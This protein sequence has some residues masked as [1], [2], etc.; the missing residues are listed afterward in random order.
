VFGSVDL[1]HIPFLIVNLTRSV[2]R[3]VGFGVM[4]GIL[5]LLWLWGIVAIAVYEPWPLWLRLVVALLWAVLFPLA[6]ITIPHRVQPPQFTL[7]ILAVTLF[8][9]FVAIRV[10]W[11]FWHPSNDRDWSAPHARLANATFH[12]NTVTIE[13]VRDFTHRGRNDYDERWETRSY[14]IRELTGV[15][16]AI[17]PF[18]WGRGG[19]AHTFLTFGFSNGEHIAISVEARLEKGENY[20]FLLGLFRTYELIYI[21]GDERDILGLRT[22][23]RGDPLYLY[24]LRVEPP[25]AQ[26]IFVMML[27]RANRLERR[28]EFYNTVTNCCASNMVRHIAQA[29]QGDY[30]IDPRVLLPGYLDNFAAERGA[31][32]IDG[33][34]EEVRDQYLVNDRD[35]QMTDSI[36]WSRQIRGLPPL[37]TGAHPATNGQASQ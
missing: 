6:A 30:P 29:F 7:V 20:N 19:L 5:F 33:P 31:L 10:L 18:L 24:P 1:G 8:A 35:I 21:V 26:A 23:G 2:L 17:C 27:T 11:S 25:L 22:N 12:G 16:M 14:D 34:L 37:P 36:S 28:P 15:D 13:N 9:G 32:R 4:Y 3:V